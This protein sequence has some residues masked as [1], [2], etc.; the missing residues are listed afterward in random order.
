ME[1]VFAI[2]ISADTVQKATDMYNKISRPEYRLVSIIPERGGY[3]F[4][5]AYKTP[6]VS[7]NTLVGLDMLKVEDLKVRLV[8]LIIKAH[9]NGYLV[10]KWCPKFNVTKGSLAYPT[11]PLLKEDPEFYEIVKL[12]QYFR[13]KG[14]LVSRKELETIVK[15]LGYRVEGIANHSSLFNVYSTKYRRIA[16]VK[17]SHS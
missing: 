3:S 4:L 11:F 2:S 9:E 12:S 7:L 5:V 16:F 8:S 15:D 10:G 1:K 14:I 17:D 13:T 6:K